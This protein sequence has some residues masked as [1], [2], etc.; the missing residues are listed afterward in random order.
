MIS[1]YTSIQQKIKSK[2]QSY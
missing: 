2:N 1:F